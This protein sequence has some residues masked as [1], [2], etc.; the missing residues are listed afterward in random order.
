MWEVLN[1]SRISSAP[2][3][4]IWI[5]E[6]PHPD[7]ASMTSLKP[8]SKMRAERNG[9]KF[10]LSIDGIVVQEHD[11]FLDVWNAGRRIAAEARESFRSDAYAKTG[12][13]ENRWEVQDGY[14]VGRQDRSEV[15]FASGVDGWKP[16]IGNVGFDRCPTARE[17]E[18]VID[19]T[20][21]IQKAD[22]DVLEGVYDGSLARST[23]SP[24][25]GRDLMAEGLI[26]KVDG[27]LMLTTSGRELLDSDPRTLPLAIRDAIV[28][29]GVKALKARGP[30]HGLG[31]W[32]HLE[33]V[34]RR[35]WSHYLSAGGPYADNAKGLMSVLEN[36]L[37]VWRGQASSEPQEIV[38]V[39]KGPGHSEGSAMMFA[40]WWDD[41]KGLATLLA[42]TIVD[43]KEDLVEIHR[44]GMS[45]SG[46]TF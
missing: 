11:V 28:E 33:T 32:V 23:Y 18:A 19:G 34:L 7:L 3:D 6:L 37:D 41:N 15:I 26:E 44:N 31:Q 17:A 8:R 2:E 10:T 38:L 12:L 43:I 30:D 24:S 21:H 46:P 27:R 4:N 22:L 39:A 40:P 35:Q 1:T 36:D 45:N 42:D 25:E 29:A 13:S 20:H 9:E 16:T 14:F 5:A